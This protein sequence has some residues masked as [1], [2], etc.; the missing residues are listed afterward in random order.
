MR[1]FLAQTYSVPEHLDVATLRHITAQ[2]VATFVLRLTFDAVLLSLPVALAFAPALLR[3][4]RAHAVG[5]LIG[6]A[7]FIPLLCHEAR[8]RAFHEWLSPFFLFTPSRPYSLETMFTNVQVPIKGPSELTLTNP[9]RWALTLVC[10]V[11][12]SCVLAG[13]IYAQ[14]RV[15][16]DVKQR[17]DRHRLAVLTAPFVVEYIL[18]LMPRG[19]TSFAYDRYCLLLL[20][21]V[22][23]FLVRWYQDRISERLPAYSVAIAAL[24][25]MYS[26][27]SLHDVFAA[28]RTSLALIHE[29]GATGVPRTAIDGGWEYDGYTQ[30]LEDGY[31]RQPGARLPDG[32]SVPVGPGTFAG[33]C[34]RDI[35]E[36]TPSVQPRYT[37]ANPRSGC[38]AVPQFAARAY[39]AW[40]PP[41]RRVAYVANYATSPERP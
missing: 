11:A 33:P 10:V 19:L 5:V 6:V 27:F 20:P 40:L 12:L 37:V 36:W 29:V 31:V 21:P 3:I 25:G 23:L 7:A 16:G 28:Y 38:T 35:P 18:L 17:E 22:L 13:T 39:T 8:R 9:V 26:V 24:V 1:W 2:N 14:K 41:F 30:L 15:G 34:S 4:A 32:H